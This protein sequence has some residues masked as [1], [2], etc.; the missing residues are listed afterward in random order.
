MPLLS[1]WSIASCEIPV[2]AASADKMA[3]V[4]RTIE[5]KSLH[6]AQ[7]R[8]DGVQ[9]ADVKGHHSDPVRPEELLQGAILTRSEVGHDDKQALAE[10][11]AFAEPAEGMVG[12][13]EARGKGWLI[14]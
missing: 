13:K 10:R 3:S 1:E 2:D 14:S 9:P 8:L 7:M 5:D 4:V 6:D 12:L 11:I